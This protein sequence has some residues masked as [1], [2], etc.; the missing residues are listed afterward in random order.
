[1]QPCPSLPGQQLSCFER[2]QSE[3]FLNGSLDLQV[4]LHK[5]RIIAMYPLFL[6]LQIKMQ[7]DP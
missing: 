2:P 7:G 5:P 3:G 4:N 1:M 6:Q